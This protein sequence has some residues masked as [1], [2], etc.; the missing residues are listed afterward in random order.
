MK[1]NPSNHPAS[2][3]PESTQANR[4]ATV[5]ERTSHRAAT[6]RERTNRAATVRERSRD[7]TIAIFTATSRQNRHPAPWYALLVAIVFSLTSTRATAQVA[8]R[9]E[10]VHTMAGDAISNGVVVVESGKI[11]AV[12]PADRVRIPQGFPVLTAK[13]VTPGLID[14]HATVGLTG[15]YNQEQDQ[16][17]L[18]RSTAIQPELRAVDAFNIHDPLVKWVRDFGVTTVHTG[19]APGELISGQTMVVKT[20]GNT[21]EAATLVPTA[22]VACT[23]ASSA[24]KGGDKSPGTRAKMMAMLRGKLIEAREYRSKRMRAAAQ[25]NVGL[26][27]AAED[28]PGCPEHDLE[29]DVLAR[30]IAGELPL[31]VTAQRAQDIANALR[32][33]REFEF[34]LV[35]DGAAESYLLIDEIK[36]AKV[37]VIVHPLM[38]RYFG[39]LKNASFETPAKLRAAG[40]PVCT[41]SG[42][43]DYVPKTRVVL[44][45]TAIAAANG[46][47]FEQALSAMTIDP[48]RLLKVDDRVGS[49]EV[50][51]DGDLALYDG[52]PFEYTS[53]C[54]GVV[55]NGEVVNAEPR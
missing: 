36:A 54:V 2:P 14:A 44:F 7:R 29:M 34:R 42:F 33:A 38:A 31:L 15:I 50:G 18:E 40:I 19:H 16:D 21:V 4:A 32:L 46:L 49:L 20:W 47:T 23:L 26:V 11:S 41:Q 39:E 5:R 53:H 45:E 25:V 55:I 12:G 52:D 28:A 24:R 22:M 35:L 3:A 6:V 8:V 1:K 10:I 51:K 30:V 48:A 37:P 27:A 13:V 9:G 43:E 17:Q